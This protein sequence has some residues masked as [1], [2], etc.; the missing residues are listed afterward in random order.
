MIQSKTSYII[1]LLLPRLKLLLLLILLYVIVSPADS[2]SSG[3][4][5]NEPQDRQCECT[6][7]P[8]T[9]SSPPSFLQLLHPSSAGRPPALPTFASSSTQKFLPPHFIPPTGSS[10][11]A[12]FT[13]PFNDRWASL[14]QNWRYPQTTAA[15]NHAPLY[16][17]NLALGPLLPI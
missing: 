15:H 1:L 8:A 16:S 3:L 14:L 5:Q 13:V 2:Y 6:M 12:S 17:T 7:T 11:V 9:Y 10:S 4:H